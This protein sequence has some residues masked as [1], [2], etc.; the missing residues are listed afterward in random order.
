VQ[1]MERVQFGM[2]WVQLRSYLK[3]NVATPI[4]KTYN[5]AVGIRYSDYVTPCTRKSW[6]QLRWQAAVARSV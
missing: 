4:Q 6:H 5:T 1:S 2:E 3:Q